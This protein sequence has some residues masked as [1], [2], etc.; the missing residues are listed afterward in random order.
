MHYGQDQTG[1]THGHGNCE[2]GFPRCMHPEDLYKNNVIMRHVAR[3]DDVQAGKWYFDY[4]NDKVYM[5][6]NPAGQTME[7]TTTK[8]AFS[9]ENASNVTIK[10][11]IV[12]KYANPPQFGAIGDQY[13]GKAWVVENCES[14]YN[15]GAGINVDDNGVIRNCHVYNNGQLGIRATGENVLVEGNTVSWNR[16]AGI[17]DGW[18]G[19]GSK[20]AKTD[21]I[22]IRNNHFHHNNGPG[23]WL[24]IDN[25][26]ALVENNLSEYNQTLGIFY[27]ISYKATIRCNTVRYNG[28]RDN[29]WLYGSQI[30]SSTSQDV[31]ISNN[32]VTVGTNGSNGIGVIQQNRTGGKDGSKRYFGKN[33]LVRDNHVTFMGSTGFTG[34]AVDYE[35]P[36]FW[37]TGNN[38]HINNRYHAADVNVG[39]WYYRDFPYTWSSFQRQGQDVG[40]SLDTDLSYKDKLACQVNIP[41]VISFTQ[42]SQNQDFPAGSSVTVRANITDNDGVTNAKLYFNGT[43]VRQENSAAWEWGLDSQPDA[44]LKNIPAGSYTLKIVATDNTGKI[45]QASRRFTVSGGLNQQ[46]DPFFVVPTENGKTVIF[47]L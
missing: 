26:N 24:D 34:A 18:E 39:H 23:I 11:L 46:D 40:G 9:N 1:V 25:I 33:N 3:K 47:G 30:L 17:R 28:D 16:T 31:E 43:L 45:S 42:P 14:R 13:S 36:S 44:A 10:N 20:F 27:E 5:V 6:D 32:I 15:H 41:P 21:G 35:K 19:G 2:E 12:E 7:I 38:R 8:A 37:S 29:G 22:I 4:P